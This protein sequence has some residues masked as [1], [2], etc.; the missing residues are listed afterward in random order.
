MNFSKV[1][2]TATGIM[3]F[4]GFFLIVGTA[5]T[6]DYMI[7]IGS[8]YPIS[9]MLPQMLISLAMMLPSVFVFKD[10]EFEEDEDWED[11]IYED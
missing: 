10:Y 9:E 7:E 4:I 5:G 3:G 1:I 8:Y 2:R 11:E 6:S